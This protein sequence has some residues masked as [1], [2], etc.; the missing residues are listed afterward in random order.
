MII[1]KFLDKKYSEAMYFAGMLLGVMFLCLGFVWCLVS[2]IFFFTF[3][4]NTGLVVDYRSSKNEERNT[5]YQAVVEHKIQ[6]KANIR[7]TLTMSSNQKQ[8]PLGSQVTIIYKPSSPKL[9]FIKSFEE[10]FMGPLFLIIAGIISSIM[11]RRY[12]KIYA[13]L[14]EQENQ[15]LVH[16]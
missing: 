8:Y 13:R 9:V 1:E 7:S 11:S 2:T 14:K 5:F 12:K 4:T 15:D 10:L 3:D 6:S 16:A